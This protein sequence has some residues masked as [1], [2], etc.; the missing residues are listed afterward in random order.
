M[1]L[2][3]IMRTK[4]ATCPFRT[5]GKGYT[6]V[7]GLLLQRALS[8]A[9]PICHSTGTSNVTPKDKKLTQKNLACRGARDIQLNYFAEIGYLPAATDEAWNKKCRAMGLPVPPTVTAEILRDWE[10]ANKQYSP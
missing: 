7:A 9:T 2:S 1:K 10:D 4:C 5:D 3:G 8:E 6:E